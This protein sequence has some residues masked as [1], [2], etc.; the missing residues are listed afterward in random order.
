M[1]NLNLSK[2]WKT[3]DLFEFRQGI[4]EGSISSDEDFWV[5]DIYFDKYDNKFVRDIP[6]TRVTWGGYDSF[7]PYSKTG[8]V[9][10]KRIIALPSSERR[11]VKVFQAENDSWIS[12]RASINI[13]FTQQ[14]CVD[15]YVELCNKAFEVVEKFAEE[16]KAIENNNKSILRDRIDASQRMEED[17]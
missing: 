14:E 17:Q 8:R 16:I 12:R 2:D 9:L 3:V 15:F 10:S 5:C 13:F 7:N 4:K 1:V 6:P 11:M